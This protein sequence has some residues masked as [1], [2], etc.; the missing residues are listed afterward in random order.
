VID[1]GLGLRPMPKGEK[2]LALWC[3]PWVILAPKARLD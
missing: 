1:A 2:G 3:Q